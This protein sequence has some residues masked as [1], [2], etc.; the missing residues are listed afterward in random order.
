MHTQSLVRSSKPRPLSFSLSRLSSAAAVAAALL[1]GIGGVAQAAN[2]YWDPLVDGDG[3]IGGS[4]SWDLLG[5]STFW[6][7]NPVDP[8]GSVVWSNLATDTAVFGNTLVTPLPPFNVTVAAITAG[9]VQFDAAGY[10]LSGGTL[11]MGGGTVTTNV[12][13]RIDSVITGAGGLIANGLAGT[14]LVLGGAN[15]FTGQLLVNSGTVALAGLGA[16]PVTGGVGNETVV[17][18]GATLNLGGQAYN[19]G[20][21][22]TAEIFRIAGTGDGGVGALI[23][24]GASQQGATSKVVLT[25]DATFNAGGDISTSYNAGGQIITSAGGR[26][27]VRLT[28]APTGVEND[29]DLAGFTLTKKGTNLLALVNAHVSSGNIV[30]NEGQLNF[31]A[32]TLVQGTGTVT[33][34]PNGKLGFFS[35]TAAGNISRQIVVNGGTI[36]DPTST[37]AA[38]TI[39]AP[40]QVVGALNPNFTAISGNRTTLS[41]PITQSG[42]TGTEFSKRGGGLLAFS[43]IANTFSAPVTIYAGT[44]GAD[45]STVLTGGV[46]SAAAAITTDTPL[47][48]NGTITL[49]GGTLNI[50]ANMAN[51]ATQQYFDLQRSIVVD[52][53]P[54]G[55]TFDRIANATQTDKHVRITS[56]TMR[57]ASAAN[58]WSIGQNQLTFTQANTH[59]LDIPLM[60]MNSDSV[61]ATGD[62][63]FSGNILSANRNSL[64]RI[65]GNTTQFVTPGTQ[66]FNAFFNTAGSLRVGTGFGT[67]VTDATVTVGTGNILLAPGALGTWRTPTNIAATNTIEV[68]SQR[69]THG[70]A[71]FELFTSVPTNLRTVNSGVLGVGSATAFGNIDLNKLGDGTWRIGSAFTG[72]GNGTITGTIAA[73]A[74]RL[75]RL[76]AGAAAGSVVT[77]SATN[78]ITGMV[79]LEVGSPLINAVQTTNGTGTALL[80]GANDYMGGTT[81]NRSAT[82]RFENNGSVGTGAV[83]VFGTIAAQQTNG[84]FTVDGLTNT[85]A[86]NFYGG[87]T[88]S[89][90]N[91][92][93]TTSTPA[94]RWGDTAPINLIAG[95][96]TYNSPNNAV[97]STGETVGAVTFSGGSNLTV[98][99]TQVPASG[100]LAI[101]N[102]ASLARSGQ[103][104]LELVRNGGTG[105]GFTG[106]QRII[107]NAGAPVPVNGM[108]SPF[109][110]INGVTEQNTFA[111]YGVNG[112]LP[113][114][115]TR[116]IHAGTTAGIFDT[117][118]LAGTDLVFADFASTNTTLTLGD[119]PI[120]HAL[121]VGAGTAGTTI[122]TSGAN[123]TITLRSGGLVISGDGSAGNFS[124]AASTATINP[125]LVFNSGA[126]VIEAVINARSGYTGVLN[127]QVTAAGLSKFGAGTLNLTANQAALTGTVSVNQGTLQLF[128][129]TATGT[130]NSG[131]NGLI[132][133]N[134]GQLNL[135]SNNTAVTGTI[136]PT[137]QNGLSVAANI[138]IATV[139]VNRSGADTASSGTFIFNPAVASSTG[140]QL[141]GSP[142]AQG[143]TLTVSGANYGL[144]FGVN[145][146][147][148]FAGNVTI[149][150]AVTVTLDN[151]PVVTGT[152]PV[153]TKSGAGT[154]IVARVN[155]GTAIAAGTTAVVNAGVLELRSLTSLG[156]GLQTAIV[157]NAG[158]LN[159]RRDTTGGT[160]GGTGTGYPVTV[161]GSA[162]ISADR[163]SAGTNQ[164]L[165]LGKLTTNTNGTVTINNGN[166]FY[167]SFA[168]AQLNGTAFIASNVAA[169]DQDAAARFIS[170]ADVSGGALVKSGTG[171]LHL[172]NSNSTYDGGTYVQ[173]GNVR[174]RGTNAAGTGNVWVNPGGTLDFN[175]ATNINPSQIVFVR[176]NGAHL[177]MISVN[178]NGLDHPT[179]NIDATQA[180]VGIVG[181]SNGTTGGYTG[182][183]GV[184]DLSLLYGGGWSFGGISS[185]AYDPVFAG[186]S[187]I[188]GNNSLYRLGGGG[189]S[190]AMGTDPGRNALTNVL[191]GANDVRLGFDSSNILPVNMTNF[192]F[193]IAGTNNYNDA[194]GGRTTIHRG[195]VTRLFS[196]NDG[197]HSGL[198]NSAV[199][200]FGVISLSGQ[201]SLDNGAGANVNAVTL[202]PGSALFFDNANGAA[203]GA[204][205]FSGTF[206]ITN[207]W[208]DATPIGLNGAMINL[209]GANTLASSETVGDVT[210]SRGARLRAQL[211]GTGGTATLSLNNLFGAGP[212]NTVTLATSAAG[213]LGAADKIIVVNSPP[214][215]TNGMVTPSIVNLSDNT[216]VTHGVNGFQNV[217]YDNTITASPIPAGLATTAKVDVSTADPVLSDNPTIYALRSTRTINIAGPF[218][219]LTLRSGGLILS[220]L[221]DNTT[222][223]INPSL[224]FNNGAGNIEARIYTNAAGTGR[225]YALNG[226]ITANGVTKFGGG[227]LL[228]NVPQPNYASGWTVNSG[229]LQINDLQGLGQSVAGNGVTLNGALTTAGLVSQ[230]FAQTTLN[231]NRDDGS[232]ETMVFTGGPITVVNEGTIRMGS[233]SNDRNIQIP[234]VILD[235]TSTDSR[236]AL[237]LDVPFN[238]VR[239][240]TTNLTLLDDAI[241]RV[242][243]A[244]STADTGRVVAA[245]ANALT[246][247][248]KNLTKIGNRTLELPNDNSATFTGGTITVSQGTLR[249]RHN[250]SLG[251][252][253]SMTTIE[254]N[255]TLEIDTSN[256]TPLA[257]VNQLSGSIERWNREDA[258][259]A[260]YNLP[261]GV[262]LQL[263]ANL[264]APRT[265]GLNGG[266]IE[267][268]LWT[269]HVATGVERTIGSGVT[270]NLLSNSYVGQ[271]ILQGQGYDAGRLP[272]VGQPFADNINSAYLR[273]DGQITGASDLT[274]T[275]N[276]TVTLANST[277][278]YNNT[279]VELGVLR[280]G[281]S[282]ALPIAGVLTTRTG[283]TFDLYGFDQSVIGLGTLDGGPNPG[284]VGVGSA[285]RVI[286]SGVTD[287]TLTVTGAANYTYN[288]SIGLNAALTKTGAGTLTLSGNNTYRGLTTVSNGTL[289][290]NAAGFSAIEGNQVKDKVADI[291][292]NG[293]TLRWDASNQVG[294]LVAINVTAGHAFL[295][296]KTE[297]FYDLT[298][299]GSGMFTTGVGGL[300]NIPDPTLT[301]GITTL[302]ADSINTWGALN[303][304][305]GANTVQGQSGPAAGSVSGAILNVGANGGVN[306]SGTGN[307]NLTINSDPISGGKVVLQGNITSTVTAGQAS[308]TNDGT[309]ASKGSLNLNGAT[310][311]VSVADGTG[312][313]DLL[314]SADIIGGVGAALTKTGAGRLALAGAQNYLLLNTNGGKTD[315]NSSF[316]GGTAT[317]NA[318]ATTNFTVSQT[319]AA[320]NIA[321]GVVVTL[322]NPPPASPGE[323]FGGGEDAGV[324]ALGAD[325]GGA[326][327]PVQGVPEPG[328]AAL[329]FGGVLTMLGLRRRRG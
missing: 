143:Q 276:D 23:N 298:V 248:N 118:L 121:R 230:A 226:T 201:A 280:I 328:T 53:A 119:N 159:M 4:G 101:L 319:L 40:I 39:G 51:D 130:Y 249:V 240:G 21:S 239:H 198:S 252:V 162:T 49:A 314:I 98:N 168:G 193:S 131:G 2:L 24:Q 315:V 123:T 19:N 32:G 111:T 251:D 105:A 129:P 268:F 106:G 211:T 170:G 73:G 3:N 199:N 181:I 279:I 227:N 82:L 125:N 41:G 190:F 237:T 270:V 206:N 132:Q 247:T 157:L 323:A 232:P 147:N 155:G 182:S 297:T 154:L 309:D 20:G 91:A 296:G 46:P 256:F 283:G 90:D 92:A 35:I 68:V 295:N 153:I 97:V 322:G 144:Q 11:T 186:T 89:L 7:P 117:G 8:L 307:P 149:N 67:P 205:A 214:V 215:S 255:A 34:N 27:D 267:A 50:R 224:I 61:V 96:L 324:F 124:T 69:V 188:A 109:Y 312:A 44:L 285:G 1:A 112:F 150:N 161:N 218:T 151:S 292:V 42:F 244:G 9:G 108:V 57:P 191:T 241:I 257:S 308:I 258:R 301:G 128:G 275:G 208:N 79:G 243:D 192:Q 88:L 238:R 74:G 22:R 185:G 25:A 36:G 31:E 217:A 58:G 228:I 81:V 209:I 139:D 28:T 102:V 17:A 62:H 222:I 290:M 163:F 72:S 174:L 293:G 45:F 86:T 136:N 148:S 156:T 173:A 107:V 260:A 305:G 311:T 187:I 286:N 250:G 262:N 164:V 54:S 55:I 281:A 326:A 100:H 66:Q 274:K 134:G 266:T 271:N 29:L 18:S 284:G 60:T 278:N 167:P 26:F 93:I 233:V 64:V 288:G 6:D 165:G 197:T 269:D 316:T 16:G 5:T 59:R 325:L 84:V 194:G 183:S 63:T 158:T 264:L 169:G 287:N 12:S 176:G 65:N 175:S 177:P 52:R 71:N 294:D 204:G 272:A 142:G 10:R 48:T 245:Y 265:I 310:R 221:I 225:N 216:F 83:N 291:L 47:G 259:G 126:G 166:G 235:S 76:G 78:A 160:Y 171:H 80:T 289:V 114:T 137:M 85:I 196:N 152:N 38:Q 220:N 30:L 320:L 99:R 321:D 77:V 189:T 120:I 113:V 94:N 110:V 261:S 133:L 87:A 56:L 146:V 75:V 14:T 115:Y 273:I 207:R 300:T 43:N 179:T 263:N 202:Q 104:T 200:V 172:L 229:T 178:V 116:T 254:R 135:R 302:N 141:L 103:G 127:G 234:A 13:G 236:V 219:N 203:N 329:L 327:I 37:G 212:G 33:V 145:G 223:N 306:F 313:V 210:Y 304:S 303:I 15:T 140:L 253:N 70:I 242:T 213:T 282:N 122:A 95:G 299:S 246:G 184:L 277:N 231:F 318:N 180:P 138:P 195:M 317:V